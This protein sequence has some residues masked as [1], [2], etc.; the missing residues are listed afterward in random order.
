[1]RNLIILT[2]LILVEA[3]MTKRRDNMIKTISVLVACLIAT[4]SA[5]ADSWNI[6]RN[7][8]NVGAVDAAWTI[9]PAKFEG[10]KGIIDA[11]YTIHRKMGEVPQTKDCCPPQPPAERLIGVL[12]GHF[13]FGGSDTNL[14]YLVLA[15]T[16]LAYQRNKE[17]KAGRFTTVR[18]TLEFGKV[19]Y[20]EDDPL[21]MDYYTEVTLAQGSRTWGHEI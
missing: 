19:M 2:T 6:N 15:A 16:P 9:D 18:D 11:R 7:H 21:G 8:V 1:M 10:T 5:L 3:A 20:S 14:E 17:F 12:D 13:Q 4:S